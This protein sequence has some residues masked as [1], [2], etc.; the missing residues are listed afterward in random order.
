[1]LEAAFLGQLF[2]IRTHSVLLL[3]SSAAFHVTFGPAC[4]FRGQIFL[5]SARVGTQDLFAKLN[6]FKQD[7]FVQRSQLLRILS[8]VALTS[9]F[10]RLVVSTAPGL[11]V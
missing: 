5:L 8:V 2:E 6:L 4:P 3:G 11:T 9:P 1:M 10:S 7:L